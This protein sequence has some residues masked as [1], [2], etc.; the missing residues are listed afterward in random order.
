MARK[1]LLANVTANIATSEES[2]PLPEARF[3]YARRGASRSM[4]QSLDEMADI[5]KKMMTSDAIVSI[6]PAQIDVSF[7]QDRIEDDE[8]DFVAL[9]EAIRGHGQLTPIL[10][11]PHPDQSG[12]YMTVFGHRRLRAAR[13]LRIPVLAVVKTVEDIAHVIAQGQENSARANL[14]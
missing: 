7:V 4:M 14:S 3:D 11:R 13:E 12:R 6:D 1:N 2:R 10:V 5:A 9:R 8:E